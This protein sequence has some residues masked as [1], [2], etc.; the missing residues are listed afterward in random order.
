MAGGFARLIV[1][2][3][4]RDF[5]CGTGRERAGNG[6]KASRLPPP[7][8]GMRQERLPFR[9]SNAGTGPRV[10]RLRLPHSVIKRYR[11]FPRLDT[12]RL[13]PTERPET[14]GTVQRGPGSNAED[15]RRT[16]RITNHD[17]GNGCSRKRKRKRGQ[18]CLPATTG[19]ATRTMPTT[20]KS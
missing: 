8:K 19:P 7:A 9:R 1:A 14:D 16:G 2:V 4:A 20:L 13:C 6:G 12:A 17:G 18:G 5:P 3:V 11:R 10:W 15:R